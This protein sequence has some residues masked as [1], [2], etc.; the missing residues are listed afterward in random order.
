MCDQDEFES[1]EEYNLP[2]RLH[3]VETIYPPNIRAARMFE[4]YVDDAMEG[5]VK[6]FLVIA[7]K[8]NGDLRSSHSIWWGRT[9]TFVGK[10]EVM[11]RGLIELSDEERSFRPV[12]D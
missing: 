1:L 9:E 11:K 4:S 5:D 10:M 3:T 2:F 7:E 12:E 6:S 8:A